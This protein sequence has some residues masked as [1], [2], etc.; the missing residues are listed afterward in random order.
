MGE[1]EAMELA[2]GLLWLAPTDIGTRSGRL[3]RDA[4]LTLGNAL[5]HEGKKAGIARAQKREG[6]RMRH[7]DD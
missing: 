2:Y 3:T 7:L 4:R 1:R 6:D 5:G